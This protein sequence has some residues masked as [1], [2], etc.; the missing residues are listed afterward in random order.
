MGI[1]YKMPENLC[2]RDAGQESKVEHDFLENHYTT[3]IQYYIS[4]S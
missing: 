1:P 4:T 2:V 3:D